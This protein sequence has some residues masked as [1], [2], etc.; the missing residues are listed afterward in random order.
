MWS[1]HI[2]LGNAMTWRHLRLLNHRRYLVCR[3]L[4]L[5]NHRCY[6]VCLC[7]TKVYILISNDALLCSMCEVLKSMFLKPCSSCWCDFACD[8]I[9]CGP[10][11]QTSGACNAKNDKNLRYS[12]KSF[13]IIAIVLGPHSIILTLRFRCESVFMLMTSSNFINRSLWGAS[14]GVRIIIAVYVC[15]ATANRCVHCVGQLAVL[16]NC[17]LVTVD[18]VISINI[19][20]HIEM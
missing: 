20:F 1:F 18:D 2:I 16:W 7:K 8:L 17:E 3:H 14:G 10:Q 11:E 9:W 15:K 19:H 4:R 13:L 6:L 12:K 5:L